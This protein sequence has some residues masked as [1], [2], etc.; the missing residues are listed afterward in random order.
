MACSLTLPITCLKK[1]DDMAVTIQ[2]DFEADH[3]RA[4]DIL[5][6]IEATYSGAGRACIFISDAAARTLR[7]RGIRYRIMAGR[8]EEEPPHAPTA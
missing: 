8:L 6:D 3:E 1:E 2:F 5:F 4:L 7:E